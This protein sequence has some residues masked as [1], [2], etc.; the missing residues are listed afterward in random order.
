MLIYIE[1]ISRRPNI[2]LEHFH[3]IAQLGQDG[4][5]GQY[6][7]DRLLLHLGRTWRIGPEPEYVAVWCTPDSGTDRLDYWEQAFSTGEADAFEKPMEIAAR[8]D[9]AGCYE[10]LREPEAHRGARYYVEYFDF[11]EGASRTDVSGFFEARRARNGLRLPVLVDRIGHLGP[12]PRGLAF[13]VLPSYRLLETVARECEEA[14]SP[15]IRLVTSGLY[16]ELGQ[17]VL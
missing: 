12:E 9:T 4:W 13:W 15:P 14:D 16:A 3:A 2:S 8:L 5:A 1:Y 10:P 17:E 6:G 11:E 7:A